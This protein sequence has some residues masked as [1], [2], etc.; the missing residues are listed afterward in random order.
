M[1]HRET[2]IVSDRPEQTGAKRESGLGHRSAKRGGDPERGIALILVMMTTTLFVVLVGS[3]ALVVLTETA[4]AA[5]HR[6]A[7]H[8]LYAAEAAVEFVL[9]EIA[10]VE[11]WNEMLSAPGQSSFV[12]G[13]PAGVRQAGAVNIDLSEATV[14]VSAAATAPAGAV[15]LPPVLFAFGRF[16]DLVPAGPPG[17]DAYVAVWLADRSPPP[18]DEDEPPATLSVVG[19]AFAGRGIRRGV[20]ALVERADASAV[21]VLAWRELP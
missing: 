11:D 9:Q 16:S 12:D 6:N 2:R 5:N 20:E 1:S 15:A 14:D 18:K 21:R 13:E 10:V 4:V 19:E 17:S 8:A 3:L 7:G